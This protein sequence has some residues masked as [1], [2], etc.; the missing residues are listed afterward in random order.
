MKILAVITALSLVFSAMPQSELTFDGEKPE[1]MDYI[2]KYAVSFPDV[3]RNDF[4][5]LVPEETYEAEISE[6]AQKLFDRQK[7]F[8]QQMIAPYDFDVGFMDGTYYAPVLP[9]ASFGLIDLNNDG[10]PE[11]FQA[12]VD[13]YS[14]YYEVN[15]YDPD[16]EAPTQPI[17]NEVLLGFPEDGKSFFAKN[18]DGNI[19]FCS[20]YMH[21]YFMGSIFLYE[22]NYN[23]NFGLATVNEDNY[24]SVGYG[25]PD[26]QLATVCIVISRRGMDFRPTGEMGGVSPYLH[27]LLLNSELSVL[28]TDVYYI[29]RDILYRGSEPTEYM[30]I[31][32]Y[33][34][35]T[36]YVNEKI[37]G[38]DF[39]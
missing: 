36:Q 28:D 3:F 17:N 7:H 39:V 14:T 20:G 33:E 34:M 13:L 4:Y 6:E 27:D 22:L 2:D 19:V 37:N 11:A 29:Y 24:F 31:A 32:A 18:E 21:S 12:D 15:F 5:Q 25:D 9:I 23:K 8:E 10:T 26:Y 1:R 16:G 35:Y 38:E 30:G